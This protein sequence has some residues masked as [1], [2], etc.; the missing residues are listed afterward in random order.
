MTERT[1]SALRF[2]GRHTSAAFE[3]NHATNGWA[4]SAFRSRASVKLRKSPRFA[5]VAKS[6][7]L[8]VEKKYRARERSAGQLAWR[9]RASGEAVDGARSTIVPHASSRPESR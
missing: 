2:T 3:R 8:S 7:K 5:R 1:R 9:V 6:C 4:A